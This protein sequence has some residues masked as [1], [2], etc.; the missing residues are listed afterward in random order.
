MA[1]GAAAAVLVRHYWQKAAEP[2][3]KRGAQEWTFDEHVSAAGWVD[4]D[5][6]LIA[7]ETGLFRFDL[8]SGTRQPVCKLE[9]DNPLTRSN[10]GRA[11]PWGGFWIGTMGKSAEAEAGAIYRYFR[12]ELRLLFAPVTIPNAICFSPD[13]RYGYFA[14]TAKGVIWRQALEQLHGW[15]VG[16]PEV[17]VDCSRARV[18]PDGAVVDSMGRLWNAQWGAA[19]I[20]CYNADGTFSL[21]IPFPAGQISC[22]AFGGEHLDIL[23]ATSA[24]EGLSQQQL[25]AQPDAGKTFFAY[26]GSPGQAEHRLIL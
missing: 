4:A 2:D 22:P 19:R 3:R 16:E 10:D 21:A 8:Q 15:P 7:G 18:S 20:A 1:S 26:P 14:D 13:G 24:T 12:G 6:L 17:F 5:S 9:T 23:F 25:T 11:D